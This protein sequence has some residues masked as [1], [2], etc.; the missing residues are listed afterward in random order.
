MVQGIAGIVIGL[1][2]LLIGLGKA[3]VSRNPEANAAFV[4]RWARFFVI[5]GPIIALG[6][7]GMLL[8]VL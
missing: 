5:A 2:F 1:A 7:V 4:K 3:P 8:D 6:G